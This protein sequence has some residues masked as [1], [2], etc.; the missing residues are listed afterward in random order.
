[1]KPDAINVRNFL[2]ETY[3]KLVCDQKELPYD[4]ELFP[5][6]YRKAFS[7]KTR[8]SLIGL[9][10]LGHVGQILSLNEKNKLANIRLFLR[11]ENVFYEEKSIK[12]FEERELLWSNKVVTVKIESLVRKCTV[13]VGEGDTSKCDFFVRREFNPLTGEM[14]F[15]THV[16]PQAI[17]VEK[18]TDSKKLSCL[19]LFSGCGGLSFGFK[20][21]LDIQW[22]LEKDDAAA[23]AFKI[24]FPGTTVFK[25]DGNDVMESLLTGRGPAR[26]P[27]QGAVEVILA[28]PPCQGFS[29]MN[30]FRNGIYS[31]Y[32]NSLV[33]TTLS[34]VDFYR[35]KYFIM[36][37]VKNFV[38]NGD[39]LVFKLTL[40]CLIK[41]GYQI[42]FFTLQA[43][44]Y[45]L[46][47][48]RCRA[49][50]IAAALGQKLPEI[51]EGTHAFPSRLIPDSIVVD[52][53]RYFTR[54]ETSNN[55]A[56][57]RP[58]TVY[59]AIGDLPESTADYPDQVISLLPE[60]KS[61]FFRKK[62]EANDRLV[63]DH[64]SRKLSPLNQVRVSHIPLEGDWRDLPN[65]ETTFKDLEGR[66]VTTKKIIYSFVDRKT[67]RFRGV[68]PCVAEKLPVKGNMCR[69]DKVRQNNTMIPWYLV[70]TANRNYHWTGVFGRIGWRDYFSTTV[71][72]PDPSSK[73]G[74]VIHPTQD[75]VLSVREGA[76]SQ[77]FPDSFRFYGKINDRYRQVSHS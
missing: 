66:E 8:G 75:R 19:D 12:S 35:P 14:H 47:Q 48:T 22:A 51:P 56:M 34:F 6:K 27:K 36:E 31:Q 77:G 42:R 60:E 13:V 25:I 71:S 21:V 65:I 45:G 54:S 39:S 62:L 38:K 53:I 67:G 72:L 10:E 32:K 41:M 7:E 20:E 15:L 11:P 4:D 68:C 70:H 40:G 2:H 44:N 46:P 69:S 23:Q 37:N 29:E 28:G 9:I 17:S 58:I 1:M 26:F 64:T 3:E 50:I 55:F 63:R 30:R 49:F 24:N 59:D 52:D 73:Q 5:E 61:S 16:V 57:Y 76:R 43:G 18:N 33:A 74:R